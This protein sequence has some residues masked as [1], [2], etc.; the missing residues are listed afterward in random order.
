M[1]KGKVLTLPMS[2]KIPEDFECDIEVW[3]VS[4]SQGGDGT[5]SP[6]RLG[7]CRTLNGIK[8]QNMENLWQFSKVYPQMDHIETSGSQKGLPNDA[9]WE[10][11]FSGAKSERAQRYPAGKGQIP[12]YSYWGTYC[13]SY[14]VARKMIYIPE[15]AKLCAETER[16][17]EL[18]REFK[19]GANII[20]RD[21]DAYTIGKDQTLMDV[22]N[23][24]RR[25]GHGFV[26]AGMLEYGTRFYRRLII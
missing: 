26:I 19:Q 20:I 8:F 13:L 21:Y 18:R 4:R 9:W 15:Y 5:L 6:F 3:S 11:H 16:Y 12:A 17:K 25:A 24:Q 14:I 2:A 22:F 23:S 10:W 7:P 1:A